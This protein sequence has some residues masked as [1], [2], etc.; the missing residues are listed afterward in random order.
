MQYLSDTHSKG[1]LLLIDFEKAFDSISWKFIDDVLEFFN[2]GDNFK[3]YIKCLNKDFKLCVIQHGIFSSF[4]NVGRGCRQGDPISPYIFI[5]CVEILG[6]M[7]PQ[8]DC[9]GKGLLMG[10]HSR[11]RYQVA[12]SE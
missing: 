11:V 2:F 7:I 12:S 5:L 6:I 3:H 1:L 4:F 10:L 9:R 8:A